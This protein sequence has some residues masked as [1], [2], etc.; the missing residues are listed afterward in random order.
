MVGHGGRRR[1]TRE[2]N[3][4]ATRA[5]WRDWQRMLDE[6]VYESRAELA[7]GEGVSRAAVTRALVK[8]SSDEGFEVGLGK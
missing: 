7:R 3:K 2:Q 5:R 4:A 6:G 1:P 8:L